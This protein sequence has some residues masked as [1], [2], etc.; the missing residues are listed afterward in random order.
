MGIIEYLDS[1]AELFVGKGVDDSII[2]DYENTMGM[3][4]SEEYHIILRKY[5]QV[6]CN[7][8]EFT[9]IGSADRADV[10]KVT[11]IMRARYQ[12][13]KDYYVI[14]DAN[15]DNIIVCQTVSGKIY[16]VDYDK[17]QLIANNLV[18]YIRDY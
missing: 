2:N 11:D 1:Q 16:K 17:I 10:Q 7:G 14:E 4:F 5:G 9:G 8:H 6:I 3:R 15:I 13:P 18:E 12:I